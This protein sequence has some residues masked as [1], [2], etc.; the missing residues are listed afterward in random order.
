MPSL[1]VFENRSLQPVGAVTKGTIRELFEFVK[2]LVQ[3]NKELK[4]KLESERFLAKLVTFDFQAPVSTTDFSK[5]QASA[6][7]PID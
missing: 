6:I 1:E 7:K 5:F 3:E 2:G 4:R